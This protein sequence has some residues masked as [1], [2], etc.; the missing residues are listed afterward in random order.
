MN[1]TVFESGL[2][3]RKRAYRGMQSQQEKLVALAVKKGVSKLQGAIPG[4][5]RPANK[6]ALGVQDLPG[7]REN[8]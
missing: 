2:A 6:R 5:S 7:F 3:N 8:T 4:L 1:M